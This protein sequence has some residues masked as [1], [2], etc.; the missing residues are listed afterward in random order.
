[1]AAIKVL[2]R[3]GAVVESSG[4]GIRITGSTAMSGL[5]DLDASGFPDAA[6]CLAAVAAAGDSP[7]RIYGLGTLPHKESSRIEVMGTALAHAGCGI[8]AGVDELRIGPMATR[9]GVV[10]VDPAGDHRIAMAMAV[11]GTHRGG[12]AIADRAC[13]AKSYPGFWNDL[14][15]L[16]EA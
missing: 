12:I 10:V 11:L 8:V 7:S 4:E 3:S 1:V 2:A 5:G 13:V 16:Y 9:D 15:R 14:Q 6:L